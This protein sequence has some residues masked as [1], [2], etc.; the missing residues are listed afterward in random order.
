MNIVR[1]TNEY[2]YY[3]VNY[4][5]LEYPIVHVI[6]L[7]A[8]RHFCLIVHGECYTEL[9]QNKNGGLYCIICNHGV[10]IATILSI[11]KTKNIF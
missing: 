4:S 2:N 6:Q 11:T 10:S 5:I 7:Q 8:L 1:P 9:T 3:S